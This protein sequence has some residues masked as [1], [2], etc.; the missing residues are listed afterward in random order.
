MP[1]AFEKCVPATSSVSVT[2]SRPTAGQG[3]I[4]L[5]EELRILSRRTTPDIIVVDDVHAFGR[6]FDK[7]QDQWLNVSPE[8][9]TAAVSNATDSRVMGDMF[10][11][12]RNQ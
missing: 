5:W 2:S 9:I 7:E 8:T 10:A 6:A 12:W 3:D 1:G 4:P 11:V